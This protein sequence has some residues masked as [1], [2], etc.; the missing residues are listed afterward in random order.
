MFDGQCSSSC[1]VLV[2]ETFKTWQAP[3]ADHTYIIW[4]SDVCSVLS[5]L[6]NEP[7]LV[8]FE[9]FFLRCP[10]RLPAETD[11][12]VFSHNQTGWAH[13]HSAC[14]H[15]QKMFSSSAGI[16]TLSPLPS[17]LSIRVNGKKKKKNSGHCLIWFISSEWIHWPILLC[18]YKCDLGKASPE[19]IDCIRNLI[20][21]GKKSPKCNL[22]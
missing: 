15:S 6:Q 21:G 7:L 5:C 2:W 18:V 11:M 19:G 13:Q 12:R 8:F 4:P 16:E 22:L 20:K 17:Q 14:S 1:S 3:S 9:V 10:G